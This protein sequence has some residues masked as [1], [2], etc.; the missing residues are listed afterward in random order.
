MGSLLSNFTVRHQIHPM[1]RLGTFS[2]TR[3]SFRIVS[4]KPDLVTE[5]YKVSGTKGHPHKT[6]T[7]WK[8]ISLNSIKEETITVTTWN[9]ISVAK[10]TV[11]EVNT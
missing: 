6:Q 8:G 2:I 4:K 11:H 9:V 3:L 10:F 5:L 1:R 7:W